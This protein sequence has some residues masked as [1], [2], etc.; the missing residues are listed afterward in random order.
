MV[1]ISTP[2]PRERIRL[3]PNTYYTNEEAGQDVDIYFIENGCD[4]EDDRVESFL[5]IHTKTNSMRQTDLES[6]ER[7]FSMVESRVG[8]SGQKRLG[9]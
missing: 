8:T 4:I 1:A 9:S 6:F 3:N 2:P 5:T 7:C